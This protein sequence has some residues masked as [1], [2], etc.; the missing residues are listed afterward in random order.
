MLAK[1]AAGKQCGVFARGHGTACSS[2]S[3][4]VRPDDT[5]PADYQAVAHPEIGHAIRC[6]FPGPN[7]AALA[8]GGD[9]AKAREIAH[10]RRSQTCPV[11]AI[12][13]A[14]SSPNPQSSHCGQPMIATSMSTR[15]LDILGREPRG[16]NSR[17]AWQL[18]RRSFHLVNPSLLSSHSLWRFVWQPE[19]QASSRNLA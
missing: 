16:L 8:D 19:P 3:G 13:T 11:A 17:G 4:V 2:A 12:L 18:G 9:C 10:P 5:N 15:R 1:V 14:N 6:R 7:S